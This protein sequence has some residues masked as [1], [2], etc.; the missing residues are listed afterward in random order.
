MLGKTEANNT[1]NVRL[2]QSNEEVGLDSAQVS[3]VGLQKFTTL[4]SLPS[5]NLTSGQQAWVESSGRLYISNG[6]GWYNIALVNASP[7]L[8]LDQSGTVILDADTLSVTVTATATDVDDPSS[9]ITFSVESDGNMVGTGTSVSQDSSVFTITAQSADSGGT[10]GDFT[11]T[12]K[13]TDQIAVDNEALSFSLSF[14][15][16]VDSSE[17]TVFLMK[18]DGNSG[19]NSV[20]TYVDSA[21]SSGDFTETG[22]P[23]ASTFTPYRSGG[24]STYFD[25]AGD[26]LSVPSADVNLKTLSSNNFTVEGWFYKDDTQRNIFLF[27]QRGASGTGASGIQLAVSSTGYM[28]LLACTNGSS[29]NVSITGP[30]IVTDNEWHHFAVVKNSTTY[31]VYL[32]GVEEGTDT[33]SGTITYASGNPALVIGTVWSSSSSQYDWHGYIKDFRVSSTAR[34]TA[35]FDVPTSPFESDDDTELLTCSLP[36]FGD[37]S[38]TDATITTYGNVSMRGFSPYIREPW[39]ANDHIGSVYMPVGG[40][41]SLSSYSDLVTLGSGDFTIEMWVYP[42]SLANYRILLCTRAN[43]STYG[44]LHSAIYSDGSVSWIS[45]INGSSWEILK[46]STTKKV[47]TNAWNHV[48]LVRN[49]SSCKIY[50]NGVGETAG[51][52]SGTFVAPSLFRIGAEGNGASEDIDIHIADYRI[53]IGTAQYTADFTPPTAP[54]SLTDDTTFLMQNKSDANVYDA[55]STTT[56]LVLDG[57]TSS[58][59]SRKFTTSSSISTNSANVRIDGSP[60]NFQFGTGD[61]TLEGWYLIPSGQTTYVFYE[62]RTAQTQVAPLFYIYQSKLQL[63]VNGSFVAA[64]STLSNF[65]GVWC[66]IA[67]DRYN[68]STKGYFNGTSQ[69]TYSDT[70]NYIATADVHFGSYYGGSGELANSYIQDVRVTK[71]YSRY[72]GSNFTPPTAEFQL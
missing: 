17:G 24:Y 53:Q 9:I 41:M 18:A 28:A 46:T 58:T 72:K 36:Y 4:D 70:N 37:A 66:H 26:F 38:S 63:Y 23:Y 54:L 34:Y 55:S 64:S 5:S 61:F 25:G 67:L 12:F 19:T 15:N 13:A 69:F 1:A 71:G 29:F 59:A 11:L 51:T 62:G 47:N 31:K 50:I 48:A 43:T 49:G 20:I 21:G 22:S 16:I 3:A 52:T 6:S 65:Q 40:Y 27:G 8:T 60:H 68:G 32:D 56:E 33:E 30:T 10:A 44:Q 2:F 42:Q 14:S 7:T 45:S 35:A 57:A 39:K